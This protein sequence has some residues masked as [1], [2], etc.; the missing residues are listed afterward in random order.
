MLVNTEYWQEEGRRFEKLGYYTESPKGTSAYR[1]Y[2]VEQHRR[3]LEGYM[4]IPGTYYFYL[5]FYPILAKDEVTGRKMRKLPRILDI[6]LEY[7]KIVEQARQE[8]K[9]VIMLKPR[10]TGFSF[11]N[12]SLC[13]HEYNFYK[14]SKCII[15][16][17]MSELSK[18]TMQ[19]ALE[20]LNFLDK[21]TAWVKPRNPDTRDHVKARHQVTIDGV[22]TWR[23]Y[24][25][26]IFT[27]TFKDNPFASVGKSA[28][29]FLFEEAGTFDNLINSY[30]IAE[31]C[32]KDGSDMIGIP[33]IFGTGGD[34][35]GGTRD[36][37]EMYY[38][39]DKYNLLA[40]ENIWEENKGATCGWFVPATRGNLGS[41][42]GK[43]LVDK[44]GNSQQELALD[45]IKHFRDTKNNGDPKAIRDAITQYPLTPSEAF[46]RNRGSFFPTAE[47]QEHLS[48]VETNKHMYNAGVTVELVMDSGAN[49]IAKP[50]NDLHAIVDFP[51]K[52]DDVKDGAVV[53]WEEP[54]KDSKGVI[55][56][57][58]YIA[59]CLTPGE[60][61]LTDKGLMCIED[62]T[63]DD[64]LIN[65]DG[66]IVDIINLQR[67]F[68]ENEDIYELS[69]ANT[70]RTTTFTQ[71]HPIYVS[72]NILR[73]DKTINEDLFNFNYVTI[74]DVKEGQ[75]IK[76]PNVYKFKN[77]F[78]ISTL[79]FS[80]NGDYYLYNEDFWWFV[81]LVLGD[82]WCESNG[83]RICASF[84]ITDSYYINKYKAIINNLFKRQVQERVRGN[85]VELSFCHNKLNTFITDNFGKY[86]H[87]KYIP[88]WA[89]RINDNLKVQ[90]VLGYLASDGC[91]LKTKTGY[92]STEFV[93]INLELLESIQDILFSIGI[94]S[95]LSK[96]RNASEHLFRGKLLKT[97]VCYH[98]R[99][100]EHDTILLKQLSNIEDF[101]LSKVDLN[102]LTP[103]RR[104]PKTGCF[105]SNCGNYIYFKIKNINK[106]KYTGIVY[107]FECET[108]TFMCHHI[109]THNCDPVDQDK[110]ESSTSLG[111]IFIYKTFVSASKT[112]NIIVAEYTGRREKADDFYEICRRL[113]LYYNAKCLYENQLKGLKGYFEMKQ[114]LHLLY[115]QPQILKDIVKNSKVQRGYGIHMN[116]GTNGSSGIKDQCELYLKQW[117]L[118]ERIVDAETGEK[119]LNLQTILSIPLLKELINYDK[120]GN[121]DRVIA[122]M[123]CIL[124]SKEN[125]KIHV[126]EYV[127]RPPDQY[128][129]DMGKFFKKNTLR[130]IN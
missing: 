51:L 56:Y 16:A 97:K 34:M 92:F 108:H 35:E 128:W 124:Q 46:L 3:C 40:F 96:M 106:S 41:Y 54:Y 71:E 42:K 50:N 66:K 9:G 61:V 76:Y 113:L 115:E 98:L 55:P 70:F 49:V 117:L 20:G 82:G 119:V 72:D 102:N 62:V 94:I 29:I 85:C 80:D 30:N 22:T 103:R 19:M 121:F 110:A 129:N 107:N 36:F 84:N 81:G 88:E 122:F 24:N 33:I 68:K 86:A 78:D 104:R 38:N 44:N 120:E 73:S 111:S 32:W 101:K 125:H 47:L 112:H 5:N 26:E 39:P 118:E 105:I 59:G 95:G 13:V 99:L 17:Y 52:G 48:M 8:K 87:G 69:V 6:D 45:Y 75:W 79:W 114:S 109:N 27:L 65:K 11:K 100:S 31:P 15:G 83:Q 63:L 89:K 21:N 93:S 12:S 126:D 2:W 28:N 4:G 14:D 18:Y 23:G 1:E 64:K 90:L 53:I 130:Y 37:A 123:L 91:V 60:K 74:K 43:A 57:G 67:Y 127:N 7:F 25:S 116:R 77:D 58:L 10:R